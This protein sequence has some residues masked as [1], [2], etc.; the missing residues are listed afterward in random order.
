MGKKIRGI[1]GFALLFLSTVVVSS[2]IVIGYL[3]VVLL[4][5][6]AWRYQGMRLLLKLPVL[7]AYSISGIL[8][9][10]NRS[11]WDIQ[12]AGDL[13]LDRWYLLISNHQSWLDILVLLHAFKSN[14]PLLKFFMK[15][16][17]LW[18]LG[19]AGLACWILGYPFL[20]RRSSKDIDVVR[21]ACDSFKRYPT[22][23]MN[24]VEGSRFT[25]EKRQKQASPY[26][27]LLHPK[28][29]GISVVLNELNTLLS[30]IVNVTI[31]YPNSPIT[32][33]RCLC[34]D[35]TKIRVRYELLPISSD[36]LGD[37]YKD[38]QYRQRIQQWINEIW[39]RK[40]HQLS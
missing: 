21:K 22:T 17:L 37:Y 36:L 26:Q 14:L 1:I 24:F 29:A 40:D 27:H 19:P 30:G 9:L 20:S 10:S 11:Q 31:I 6:R 13:R 28:T 34:G 12:G 16:E 38:R 33:W 15:K 8:W 23:I 35:L 18:T 25:Q 39:K 3:P 7:W 2:S 4:P 5:I 32:I